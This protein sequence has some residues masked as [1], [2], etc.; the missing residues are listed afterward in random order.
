MYTHSSA[1]A[2]T[3]A[4]VSLESGV[5]GAS[6]HHLISL[7]FEGAELAVRMA[8]RHTRERDLEKKSAAVNKANVII[9][10]GLR[11]ALD[12]AQGGELA[13]Q[14]DAL[15]GY[16]VKRIM[17]AHLKNEP[18]PLEEVLG[19]LRELHE[20]WLGI[21]TAARPPASSLSHPIAA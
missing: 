13:L 10:D 19:L 5:M 16:M 4:N 20:A 18:E 14:L 17:Q 1:A 11:A 3:Y 6:P 15:Y 7:L 12:P 21:G 8:I 2:R 9:L